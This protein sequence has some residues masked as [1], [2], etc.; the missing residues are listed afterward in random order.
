MVC[1]GVVLKQRVVLWLWCPPS[2]PFWGGG[3]H[4][5]VPEKKTLFHPLRH[6]RRIP[7]VRAVRERRPQGVRPGGG[8]PEKPDRRAQGRPTGRGTPKEEEKDTPDRKDADNRQNEA[9]ADGGPG[10][11]K[12]KKEKDRDA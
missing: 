7:P 10:R 11:D 5:Q 2:S 8:V 9:P 12:G 3:G 1:K 6:L 4:A